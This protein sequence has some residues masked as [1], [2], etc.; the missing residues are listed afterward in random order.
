M[1]KIQVKVDYN[2]L[3]E[4]LL[5]TEDYAKSYKCMILSKRKSLV[6]STFSLDFNSRVINILTEGE[7]NKYKF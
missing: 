4:K 7:I 3:N 2:V 6:Y 5:K 1:E